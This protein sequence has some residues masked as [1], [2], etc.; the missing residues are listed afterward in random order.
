MKKTNK[1]QQLFPDADG[2]YVN[3]VAVHVFYA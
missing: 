1:H 3:M 2:Y